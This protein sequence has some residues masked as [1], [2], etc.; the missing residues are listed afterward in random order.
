MRKLSLAQELQP[1]EYKKGQ[2]PTRGQSPEQGT[3]RSF[4]SS[5]QGNLSLLPL[6]ALWGLSHSLL[7]QM[8]LDCGDRPL[9]RFVVIVG[10]RAQIIGLSSL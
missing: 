1:R 9:P 6:P 3:I 2:L 10:G 7:L 8:E 5:L 4:P